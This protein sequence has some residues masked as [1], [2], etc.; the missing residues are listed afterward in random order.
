M[1]SSD[2]AESALMLSSSL[3]LDTE[4]SDSLDEDEE[5]DDELSESLEEDQ[6]P[7]SS[8][9]FLLPLG[10]FSCFT[11][12]F[13]FFFFFL[14]DFSLATFSIKCIEACRIG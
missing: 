7:T 4:L 10:L 1:F 14:F 3:P 11:F 13:C 8:L 9:G 5:H 6:T 12:R 2:I